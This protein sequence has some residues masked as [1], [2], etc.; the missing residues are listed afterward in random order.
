MR[1]NASTGKNRAPR[2][3]AP[4]EKTPPRKPRRLT[5]VIV[6]SLLRLHA[7]TPAAILTACRIR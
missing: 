6:I 7:F 2:I 5:T 4:A 1:P 3:R